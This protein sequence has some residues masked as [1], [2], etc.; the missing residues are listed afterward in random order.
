MH[1]WSR[2]ILALFLLAG[3]AHAEDEP[4]Q[5]PGN[6]VTERDRQWANFT[7][8][9]AMV[10]SGQL[11]LGV[12]GSL[13]NKSTDDRT[14]DMIGFPVDDLERAMDIGKGLPDPPVEGED[15][16]ADERTRVR[17]VE[18]NR[19]DL[20]GAYG[21][22]PYAELGFDMPFFTQSIKFASD[23][24]TMNNGDVGDLVI[25]TKFRKEVFRYTS[26]GG[27]MEMS[28]PTGSERKRLGTGE[29]AFNPFV[30]A[31]FS[32]QRLAFGGH[33]GMNFIQGSGPDVF[34]WSTFVILRANDLFA[35]RLESNGRF[36]R[37]F[38]KDFNDISLW[39]GIDFNISDF[40]TVRPQ[41]LTGLTSD[42]WEWGVGL[43]VF[44]DISG[45]SINWN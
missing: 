23:D 44:V 45:L 42:A 11:R 36:F 12:Q 9:T 5:V 21:L 8:E 27:G 34:N 32:W 28:I 29:L 37:D 33:L 19:Y 25:F 18:G 39:P 6:Y 35:L 22:G 43:G 15:P 31:R 17:R 2:H 40:V 4:Q 30:N 13:I 41:G 1:G 16:F 7:R 26:V 20:L 38:G 24:P 10:E 14:P 3:V